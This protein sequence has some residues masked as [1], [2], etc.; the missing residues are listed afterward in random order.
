MQERPN[1]F[2]SA[3]SADLGSYRRAVRDVLLDAGRASNCAGP[4]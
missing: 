3:T 4:L 1:V 2:I